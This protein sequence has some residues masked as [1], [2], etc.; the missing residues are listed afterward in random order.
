M[1]NLRMKALSLMLAVCM[2]F[3][4]L[5]VSASAEENGAGK[6]IAVTLAAK[7][8]E[9]KVEETVTLTATVSGNN[10]TVS[11]NNISVSGNSIGAITWDVTKGTDGGDILVLK[12]DSNV[13]QVEGGCKVT[14]TATAKAVGTAEVSVNIGGQ[15]ATCSVK[16][17]AIP[18]TNV[19]IDEVGEN[20][21]RLVSGES[22]KLT[23]TVTPPNATDQT[24]TWKSENSEI[25]AVDENGNVTA[26]EVVESK[27]TTITATAGGKTASCEV[28][29]VP[30]VQRVRISPSRVTLE[31]SGETITLK[32][33]VTSEWATQEVTWKSYDKDI[34][35]VV[36]GP[37]GTA[38][39]TAGSKNGP[40]KI[41]ATATDGSGKRAICIVTVASPIESVTID[42]NTVKNI[43]GLKDTIS[44]E[45]TVSPTAANQKV[46][47]TCDDSGV[48]AVDK[49]TGKVTPKKYGT[50]TIT[51]TAVDDE[52]VSATC[53]VTVARQPVTS[54]TRT[55][56]TKNSKYTIYELKK[57]TFKVTASPADAS[58]PK[59]TWSSTNK[60]VA[61]VNSSGV[62]T[63]K[64]N[65]Q[66]KITATV[67]T[68]DGTKKSTTWDV[69]VQ[70]KVKSLTLNKPSLT[71]TGKG[72]ELKLTHTLTPSKP[73]NSKVTWSSSDKKVVT[74]DSKGNLVAQGPGTATITVVSNDNKNAKATCRVTVDAKTGETVTVGSSKWTVGKGVVSYAGPTS[75]TVPS[76]TIPAT[77]KIGSKTYKVTQIANNA[78]KGC[79]KLKTVTIGNNVTSIGASAFAGCKALTTVKIGSGVVKIDTN[80]FSGCS[81]LKSITISGTNL[82]TVGK[83]AFKGINK[84]AKIK[85]PSSRVKSYTNL[86]KGKGQPSSVK[87]TK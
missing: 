35:E 26:K 30:K 77:V 59:E 24:V 83:N 2:A 15:S 46:E 40:V 50:A 5:P 86:L 55:A 72:A 78:F 68:S 73:S 45:A 57:V 36:A 39:V 81:N 1:K 67:T 20:G 56:P 51:A 66:T 38:T 17:A 4:L 70:L 76:V 53:K 6:G 64:M 11:G 16:V 27:K 9:V 48:V 28:L 7:P 3:T 12:D 37:D 32:A 62:V 61:E 58:E 79:T 71:L 52:T 31:G 44:L 22:K 65:G 41:E 80:A 21:I 47:W 87:V 33:K 8:G 74:V 10:I 18:V 14:R 75:K 23:A 82:K 34:A 54:V 19:S 49:N 85:V 29:V 43:Y 13:T 60:S 25:A 69:T 63:P 84:S 42:P